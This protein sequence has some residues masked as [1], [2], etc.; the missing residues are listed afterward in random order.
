MAVVY[1]KSDQGLTVTTGTGVPSH[2]A[3]A[4]DRYTDTS[5]GNTYQYTTI[6]NLIPLSGGLTYFTEAQNSSSPNA[7]VKVDSVTAIAST[8]NADV[9]IVPKGTG[10]FT[11]AVPDNLVAGGNKRGA[12][13]V[14]LQTSRTI[15]TQVASGSQSVAIGSSNISSGLYSVSLG[16]NNIANNEGSVAIGYGSTSSNVCS[17]AI[18]QSSV[19]SYTDSLA[20]GRACNASGVSSVAIGKSNSTSGKAGIVL[21][22]AGKDYGITGRYV[23]SS[24]P[25]ESAVLIGDAQAS[26]LIITSF[27]SFLL[28]FSLVDFTSSYSKSIFILNNSKLSS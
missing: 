16:Y 17:V 24:S 11:L 3:I 9:A 20:I 8:T 13:A 21:G 19:A 7:T 25:C 1:S 4:G 6:W 12:N 2:S 14:D 22:Y 18:G 10:A 5:N 28:N 26:T 15:A 23:F 27:T